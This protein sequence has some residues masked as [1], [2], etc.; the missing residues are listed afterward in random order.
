MKALLQRGAPAG[1][2]R[3]PGPQHAT[4]MRGRG[5]SETPALPLGGAGRAAGGLGA[6]STEPDLGCREEAG[7]QPPRLRCSCFPRRGEATEWLDPLNDSSKRSRCWGKPC[8]LWPAGGPCR[9]RSSQNFPF[10]FPAL[11]PL[12]KRG[13]GELREGETVPG[14]LFVIWICKEK[15][16]GGE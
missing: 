8:Q 4:L 5:G 15:G 12:R 7:T 1:G 9:A 2:V 3:A 11:P 16:G 14:Q 13:T 10:P 6:C